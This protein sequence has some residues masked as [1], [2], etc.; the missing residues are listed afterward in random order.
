M[1]F[2]LHKFPHTRRFTVLRQSQLVIVSDHQEEEAPFR[3]G[4]YIPLV[5]RP[6]DGALQCS[7]AALLHYLDRPDKAGH[8]LDIHGQE[9]PYLSCSPR[10]LE[11]HLDFFRWSSPYDQTFV[12]FVQVA[13]QVQN[14]IRLAQNRMRHNPRRLAIAMALHDRLGQSSQLRSLQ[15]CEVLRSIL[16]LACPLVLGAREYSGF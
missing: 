2:V 9:Q 8:V 7:F 14:G 10:R 1:Q 13:Q 6:C 4:L 15:E 11:M 3:S 16:M 5:P 12:R